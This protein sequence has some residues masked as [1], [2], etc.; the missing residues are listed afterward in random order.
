MDIQ[1]P[2]N[3]RSRARDRVAA[4][5]I[6]PMATPITPMS[7]DVAV[8]MPRTDRS[9]RYQRQV[10]ERVGNWQERI[11]L[12]LRD[13]WWYTLH[14]PYVIQGVF[15]AIIGL[16]A[17]FVAS[18]LVGSRLFPNIWAL[19][20]N[21]GDMSFEEAETALRTAWANRVTINLVDGERSWTATPRD[22]G[23]TLDAEA[24]VKAANSI[25]MAGIPMGYDVPPVVEVDLFIAQTYLLNLT[26]QANFAA[27]NGGYEWQGADLVALPGRNG[28][29]LDVG[30]TLELLEANTTTIA[31]ERRL[32]LVMDPIPP[33][34]VDPTPFLTLARAVASEPF[35]LTGY[36]PFTNQS[37]TWSTDR[38]TFTSWLQASAE[39][40]SIRQD[41]FA[42]FLRGATASL[43]TDRE[44]RY[45]EPTEA[46]DRVVQAIQNG[47]RQANLRI[48]YRPEIYEVQAGDTGY[49]IADRTGLPF[50]WLTTANPGLEWESLSVGQE[51]NLPSRDVTMP[52]EP[53]ATKRI[54]V[55]LDTQSLIA[56]ENGQ[57]VFSWLISSGIPSAPTAPGVFQILTHEE[58]AYGSTYAL[59]G[60][61]GCGQWQLSWFMG[62]YEV[63]PGLM[64]G[65]HGAVLLPNGAYLGGGNVGTPYT[66]GCIM[67][68]AANGETLY[69][70]ADEGTVVE[71]LSSKYASQSDLGQ[72]A[73]IATSN[74]SA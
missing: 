31:H 73:W 59:C 43:N 34:V 9:L 1:H 18:H 27:F 28:R 61:G 11:Q 64:N 63:T 30:T 19:G 53:V 32:D 62:I 68:Q 26:E 3:R 35:T 46:T 21:L 24:T 6:R 55:N 70:W 20:V 45:L 54:I 51:I 41:L 23:M 60:Q 47:E 15:V 56:Y 71:I 69:R 40:L 37:V 48:R 7:D 52:L 66:Y 72:Q 4:R 57:Q 2:S 29:V 42:E 65:F 5:H 13:A 58:V 38:D 67:S 44:I 39:G 25:G 74:T 50:Y 14:K 8:P 16:F 12:K 10:S 22:L 17:L 33:D 49:R 36:D